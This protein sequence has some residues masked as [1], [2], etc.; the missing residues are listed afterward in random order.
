MLHQLTVHSVHHLLGCLRTL[1]EKEVEIET[2]IEPLPE[3]G[4]D[5]D[6][7]VSLLPPIKTPSVRGVACNG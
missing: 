4:E 1:L 7:D 5:E 2:I 3:G 6:I